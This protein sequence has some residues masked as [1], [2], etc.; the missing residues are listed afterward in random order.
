M[1]VKFEWTY[2]DSKF[3]IL[4]ECTDLSALFATYQ[5]ITFC[6]LIIHSLSKPK[7]LIWC[8]KYT[9]KNVKEEPNEGG[10]GMCLK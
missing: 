2:N 6:W 8:T 3:E 1:C 10:A 5:F 7:G 4:K 9:V